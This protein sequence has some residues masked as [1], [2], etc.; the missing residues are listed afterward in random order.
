[1]GNVWRVIIPRTGCLGE[2]I[3]VS[4]Q[5]ELQAAPWPPGVRKPPATLDGTY[6]LDISGLVRNCQR[7]RG[8]LIVGEYRDRQSA[9]L[10]ACPVWSLSSR[11]WTN[12]VIMSP[13]ELTYSSA[14][15]AEVA[16][17]LRRLLDAIVRGE[18]T[19]DSGTIARLEGAAA[20]SRSARRW[21][22]GRV[23]AFW[24]G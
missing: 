14:E 23:S 6:W 21:K 15:L 22:R 20:R 11:A 13:H 1:M 2:R 19:A 7:L 4:M 3:L 17:G 24:R 8:P 16:A 10:R 12:R 5:I 9:C 18:V